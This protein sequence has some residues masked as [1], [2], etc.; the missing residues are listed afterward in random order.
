MG[1]GRW[2]MMGIPHW[3]T[4]VNALSSAHRR[5]RS[6]R[7]HYPKH[8]IA[9]KIGV[10]SDP[11]PSCFKRAMSKNFL[12]NF[13]IFGATYQTFLTYFFNHRDIYI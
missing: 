12:E 6:Y 3:F 8:V 5:N 1:M 13:A 4:V 7:A 9:I 11:P 2:A 10:F